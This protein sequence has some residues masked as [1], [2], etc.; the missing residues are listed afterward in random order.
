MATSRSA[1]SRA[2]AKRWLAHQRGGQ[3]LERLAIVRGAEGQGA[4]GVGLRLL[5][6]RSSVPPIGARW[7]WRRA[8]WA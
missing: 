2:S 6:V 5:Q 8:S 7:R 1:T 4:P 3:N